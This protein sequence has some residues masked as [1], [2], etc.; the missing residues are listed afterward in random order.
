MRTFSAERQLRN[1]E[2]KKKNMRSSFSESDFVIVV[3][4][5]LDA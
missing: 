5:L 1:G 4:S 2:L 3:P